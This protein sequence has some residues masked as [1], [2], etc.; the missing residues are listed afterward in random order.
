MAHLADVS[1]VVLADADDFGGRNG[2][3]QAG[4]AEG[5]WLKAE[6][7]GRRAAMLQAEGEVFFGRGNK[8]NNPKLAG[9]VL[10]LAVE[11]LVFEL[12]WKRQYLMGWGRPPRSR[13]SVRFRGRSGQWR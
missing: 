9:A 3:E 10:D 5:H 8:I 6:G 4:L 1:A 13:Q 12:N 7:E 11:D 2:R